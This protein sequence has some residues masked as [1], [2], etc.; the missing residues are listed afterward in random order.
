M[1]QLGIRKLNEGTY[2]IFYRTTPTY[3]VILRIWDGR[4]GH[5]PLV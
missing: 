1:P 5:D 3:V 2:K 4:R